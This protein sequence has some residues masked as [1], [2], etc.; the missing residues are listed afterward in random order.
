MLHVAPLGFAS[1]WNPGGPPVGMAGRV[2]VGG[3]LSAMAAIEGFTCADE[4]PSAPHHTI[5]QER[6]A[7]LGQS[8][9]GRLTAARGV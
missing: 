7:N 4:T 5:A 6:P 1:R 2:V 3:E 9:E 8:P